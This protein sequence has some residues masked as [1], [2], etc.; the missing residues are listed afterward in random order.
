MIGVPFRGM[1]FC[2]GDK[3]VCQFFEAT[4]LIYLSGVCGTKELGED[5]VGETGQIDFQWTITGRLGVK[6]G[7]GYNICICIYLYL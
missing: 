1:P 3:M 5:G 6:V 4:Y 7:A 2:E